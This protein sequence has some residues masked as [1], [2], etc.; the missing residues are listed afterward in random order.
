MNLLRLF[1]FYLAA[2]F[3]MSTVRRA[4]L[5]R[6]V[7]RLT[8]SLFRRYQRLLDVL[9]EEGKMLVTWSAGLPLF[10][11][12][13]LWAMQSILTRLIFPNA[14][15]LLGELTARWWFIPALLFPVAAMLTVDVYFLIRVGDID[16]VQTERYF[17][18]AETWLGTWRAR[19]LKAA[20]FGYV[21]PHHIV[22][23]EVKKA[24]TTGHEMLRTLLW[25]CVL[26]T[27]LRVAVGT[28]LWVIWAVGPQS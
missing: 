9:R 21:D 2:M 3:V 19:A 8:V 10:L 16:V 12:L 26:Q 5:Y 27:G 4:E 6:S 28:M 15:L 24:L 20:T 14:E 1:E 18:Q 22:K 25:W 11:T 13:L 17:M 7:V 23:G